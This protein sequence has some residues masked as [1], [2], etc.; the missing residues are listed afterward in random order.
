MARTNIQGAEPARPLGFMQRLSPTV[1]F[2]EPTA[3]TIASSSSKSR[4][5]P[6][7]VLLSTWMGARESHIA[8]Y[9]QEYRV[10]FPESRIL[11]AQCPFTHVVMPFLAW[12]QIR[13]A[14][15]ILKDVVD[16]ESREVAK[17]D[18]SS[19]LTGKATTPRVLIHAFSNGGV[20]TTMFL[21]AA[22]KRSFAGKFALPQNI[23]IFDSC[24]GT[25]K[26]RNTARAIMQVLPRWSS[27]MV[28]AVLFSVWLFYRVVPVLQPRQNVN[29]RAIRNPRL[30][31]YEIRRTYV[32]G[33]DDQMIPPSDI[34]REAGLAAEAGFN[35]RLECFEDA[36]HV[37]IPK[38]HRD[39][40]W[41]VVKESWY[42][43]EPTT[44][45][46]LVVEGKNSSGGDLA[47]EIGSETVTKEINLV[48]NENSI[49][50]EAEILATDLKRDG[51][52][53]V[54]A[55]E[56]AAQEASKNAHALVGDATGKADDINRKSHLISEKAQANVDELKTDA[57]ATIEQGQA[58]VQQL[59]TNAAGTAKEIEIKT[60][61]KSLSK[62]VDTV[63]EDVNSSAAN[64][65]E[66][67]EKTAKRAEKQA[68]DAGSY[69]EQKLKDETED[70][71]KYAER[72]R[73]PDTSTALQA[74][75]AAA[76]SSPTNAAG[77][78]GGGSGSGTTSTSTSTS[79]VQELAARFGGKVDKST[80]KVPKAKAS[81]PELA[82]VEE[83]VLVDKTA[84]AKTEAKTEA[85]AN[86]KPSKPEQS[87]PA[88]SKS[89]KAKKNGKK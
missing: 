41:R 26:W 42:G 84:E 6:E 64:T 19:I 60:K 87:K 27:P 86:T 45:K 70:K 11:V 66:E 69:V 63:V 7:L 38:F 12:T 23:F 16:S 65:I 43:E 77:K 36:T 54:K 56:Q 85:A 73:T 76:A 39:R 59:T 80:I 62:E 89:K 68:I 25:F 34:E 5:D 22:L 3:S 79:G 50:R 28:H 67:V 71:G 4:A 1:T 40:Y 53:A 72:P 14:V 83:P 31:E 74:A 37:A 9:V 13:P 49:S 47:A 2:Y 88:G 51:R 24:P 75:L 82:K 15:H 58:K 52:D 55:I 21:Y 35:V 17:D 30:Q 32:Y 20:S 48:D 29:S 8:K 10:L 33:T 46:H 44:L 57:Y 61:R 78:S 81:Q 18:S